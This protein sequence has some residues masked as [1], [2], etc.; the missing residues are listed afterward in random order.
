MPHKNDANS[1]QVTNLFEETMDV[2]L[3]EFFKLFGHTMC[4]YVA[5]DQK[6]GVIRGFGFVNF[7][8]KEDAHRDVNKLNGYGYADLILRDEWATLV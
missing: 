1:D 2:D 3:Q 5:M 4:V 8:N 6:T 7:I